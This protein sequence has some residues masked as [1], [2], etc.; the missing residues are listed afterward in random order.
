ML[1][2]WVVFHAIEYGALVTSA[3]RLAP[4]SLNWT[5]ATPTLSEASAVT[6]TVPATVEPAVGAVIETVGGGGVEVQAP[7]K[8]HAVAASRASMSAPRSFPS[9]PAF[10]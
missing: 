10:L 5:P 7:W 6:V 9:V 1:V 4:S 8:A 3:P 2:V